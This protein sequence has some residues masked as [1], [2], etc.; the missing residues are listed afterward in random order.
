MKG[1]WCCTA[2]AGRSRKPENEATDGRP[3]PSFLAGRS[4]KVA[5]WSVPTLILALLPKCPVC[6]AAYVAMGTGISLSVSSA[7]LLKTLLLIGCVAMLVFVF[8][9]TLRSTHM[10]RSLPWHRFH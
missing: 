10:F 2:D 4:F 6:L 7:A 9:G 1:H 5:R 3:R 8:V